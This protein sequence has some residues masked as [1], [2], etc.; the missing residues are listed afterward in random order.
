MEDSLAQWI[1][2]FPPDL[3]AWSW[4]HPSECFFSEKEKNADVAKLI[5]RTL[6]IQQTVKRL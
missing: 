3:V 5:E 4:K 6:L 1:A 2:D